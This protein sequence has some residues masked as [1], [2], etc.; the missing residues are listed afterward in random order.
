[1]KYYTLLSYLSLNDLK[2]II[3]KYDKK[4]D[5][6]KYLQEHNA[7]D[8]KQSLITFISNN[9]ELIYYHK[10]V[11]ELSENKKIYDSKWLEE[12]GWYTWMVKNLGEYF[13]RS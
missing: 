12:D 6:K 10:L 8:D 1:M 11:K 13:G 5:Y 9:I 4:Q 7:D 3:I 2:K